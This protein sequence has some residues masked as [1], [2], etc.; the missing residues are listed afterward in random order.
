M[1][2]E[3]TITQNSALFFAHQKPSKRMQLLRAFRVASRTRKR[4][5]TARAL[6][7]VT[8]EE[9]LF[10]GVHHPQLGPLEQF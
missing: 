1:T 3:L 9:P 2:T 4:N 8:C 6:R 5:K 7:L 10:S